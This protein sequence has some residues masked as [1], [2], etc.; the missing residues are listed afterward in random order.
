MALHSSIKT[1][2]SL[3]LSTIN[4]PSLISKTMTETTI[5]IIRNSI[6]FCRMYSPLNVILK[7]RIIRT[8]FLTNVTNLKYIE[9]CL[10]GICALL[11]HCCCKTIKQLSFCW[12]KADHTL[13]TT[14]GNNIRHVSQSN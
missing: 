9:V 7:R 5:N 10:V 6:G 14:T 13:A 12:P 3:L 1:F 4:N 11:P 8:N 2:N